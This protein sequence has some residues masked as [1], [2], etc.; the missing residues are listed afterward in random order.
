MEKLKRLSSENALSCV[1]QGRNFTSAQVSVRDST[2]G[3]SRVPPYLV[4]ILAVL[5]Q[6][7]ATLHR[8]YGKIGLRYGNTTYAEA[9][10][11]SRAR[12]TSGN[13]L[14]DDDG[15]A[16]EGSPG[17]AN[18]KN[19]EIKDEIYATYI[20]RELCA[21]MLEVYAT[22]IDSLKENA[23]TDSDSTLSPEQN[24]LS[25]NRKRMS[26]RDLSGRRNSRDGY[27]ASSNMHRKRP[28]CAV[29][30]SLGR[31]VEEVRYLRDLLLPQGN[32]NEPI[33]H[34]GHLALSHVSEQIAEYDKDHQLY[35]KF[36]L[37]SKKPYKG[38]KFLSCEQ[39]QYESKVQASIISG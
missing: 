2:Y 1:S 22:L 34:N 13:S 17:Q 29:P 7:K 39:L 8:A 19:E 32:V 28:K 11:K 9:Y 15:G 21:Q 36:N 5:G 35:R 16:F 33:S 31:A 23:L 26:S 20:F 25:T 12:T 14:L 27:S 4:R 10:A 6:E 38:F 24:E 37:K 18:N 30:L 3:R